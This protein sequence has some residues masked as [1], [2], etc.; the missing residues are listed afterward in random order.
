MHHI[1]HIECFTRISTVQRTQN[2]A[3]IPAPILLDGFSDGLYQRRLHYAYTARR[4]RNNLC[5]VSHA[6]GNASDFASA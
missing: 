4:T 6:R 1:I 5:L 3:P 2:G